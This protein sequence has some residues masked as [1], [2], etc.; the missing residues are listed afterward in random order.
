MGKG[1]KHLGGG[2]LYAF[3]GL[4]TVLCGKLRNKDVCEGCK[5]RFFSAGGTEIL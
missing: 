4:K 1:A 2:K 5:G 3:L